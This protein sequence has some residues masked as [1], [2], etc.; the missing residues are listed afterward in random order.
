MRQ[1]L[2][3]HWVTYTSWAVAVVALGYVL[4]RLQLGELR[5]QLEGI[6]WWLV[7]TAIVLQIAPR[8]LEALRWGYL[9]RPI[10]VRFRKLFQAVYI[11][12]LYSGVLPLSGGDVV[13]AMIVAREARVGVA[14]VFSTAIIIAIWLTLSGLQ[15][16]WTLRIARGL[17]EIGVVIAV[18]AG[19]SIAIR[20]RS[21]KRWLGKWHPDNRLMR[22]LK[23]MGLDVVDTAGYVGVKSMAVTMAAAYHISLNP[24]QAAGLFAIVMIGTFLPN[25]PGNVGPWQFFCAIGLEIFSVSAAT[26]AGFSLV[27]YVVW[28]IP[29]ILMGAAALAT[30]PFKWSELRKR[31]AE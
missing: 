12:T 2:R 17:L 14:R 22:R 23:S 8:A 24:L 11:G 18:I 28:T 9:L 7:L 13:R 6:N 27:A 10:E 25:T 20:Q 29:P 19:V 30:S 4:S 21:I 5:K 15:I 26:A 3:A 16:P 31:E 1:N